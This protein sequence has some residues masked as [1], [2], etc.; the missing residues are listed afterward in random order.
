M[1]KGIHKKFESQVSIVLTLI[2]YF[3]NSSY[4]LHGILWVP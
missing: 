2:N 4:D 1:K 3:I